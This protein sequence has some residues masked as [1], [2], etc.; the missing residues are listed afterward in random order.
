MFKRIL[1]LTLILLHIA[2]FG[3]MREALAY[4]SSSANYNLNADVNGGGSTERTTAASP[5]KIQFD[6]IGEPC[7][8]ESSS[9]NYILNAGFIP[10][11]QSNP[12]TLKQEIPNYYSWPVDSAKNNAFDLDDYFTS[13]EGY[14][15]TYRASGNNSIKVTIEPNTHVVIFSANAGWFGV[16]TIRFIATD[17]E[18]NEFTSNDIVLQVAAASGT[19]NKPVIIDTELSPMPVKEGDAVTLTVKAIDL[20]GKKL[21]FAYSAYF[22]QASTW[23]DGV[24]WYSRAAWQA[25]TSGSK[26]YPLKITITEDPA[27]LSDARDLVVNVGNVNNPPV[28]PPIADIT[29]SEGQAQAVQIKPQAT[30]ADNDVIFY[31]YSVPF[32]T[33]GKWFPGYDDEGV[34]NVTVSAADGIDM[35]TRMAKVTVNHTNRPPK[36]NLTL[37]KYTVRPN[38]QI[39]I[40]VSVSDPDGDTMT[41]SLKKDGTEIANGSIT[42]TYSSTTSFSNIANHKISVTLTDAAGASVTDTKDVDVADPNANRDAINPVMGDFNGDALSDLGLYNSDTAAWEI[43]LAD[44]LAPEAQIFKSASVWLNMPD[45][46]TGDKNWWPMGGDFNGDALTDAGLYNNITGEFRIATSTGAGF[47]DKG[48]VFKF[49]EASYSWQPFTGNFN[50]DKYTDFGLY[51]KETGEVRVA[52]GSKDGF[53]AFKAWATLAS[54]SDCVV[55]GGDYNGDGLMDLCLFRKSSGEFKVVFSN[56]KAFV[57]GAVWLSGFANDKDALISDFNNDG[58]TDVGYWNKDTGTWYYAISTGEKFVNKGVWWDGFGSSSDESATTGDFD[59]NGITDA[60]VFDKDQLGINRWKIKLSTN[61]PADLLNLIDNGIGGQTKVSYTY[62]ATSEN[63]LLPFPVC[64]AS[65]IS[66]VN[67]YPADRAATYTQEFSFSGGYFDAVEREFRGFAKVKVTDISDP[68]PAQHSYAETYFYQGRSDSGAVD[69]DQGAKKGQIRMIRAYDGDNHLISEVVNTY[70][71]QKSGPEESFLGF[72]ALTGV[73]STVYEENGASVITTDN[74]IYDNIGN[75]IEAISLGAKA[76]DKRSTTTIYSQPYE[77]GYNRPLKINIKDKDEN[78]V[79][80]KDFEYDAKGNLYRDTVYIINSASQANQVAKTNITQYSYDSYGNLN[81]S[82]DALGN[83]VITNYEDKFHAYPESVVNALGYSFTYIYEPKFGVIRTATDANGAVTATSY[84]TLGRPLEAV[85]ALGEATTTFNYGDDFRSKT[86]ANALG[87]FKTEYIDG[88]GRTY[89]VI[90]N[91]EDGVRS[92]LV[93]SETY[94]NKRGLKD[95]ESLP[96]YVDEDSAKIS[97]ARYEYD[98]RGRIKKTS[99]DFPGTTSDAEASVSY[100]TPLYTET[101]DSLGHRKGALKDVYG[102]IIEI[103]EF[104]SGEPEAKADGAFHTYYEYDIQNNLTKT[105]DNKGNITQVFY[106]SIGRKTRMIDPDMG[107]WAYEYDVLG[108]LVRQTDAKGQVLV[109]EYDQ[110][111]RLTKKLLRGTSDEVIS[112]YYY[113]DPSKANCVGRLSR[114]KDKS[115]LTDFFYDILGRETK[116]IKTV[117]GVEFMVQREY[118]VLDR[119]AKL[120]YPDGEVVNYVYSINSGLLKRVSSVSG[121]ASAVNYVKDIT[122]NAKGQ[123]TAI[124]YGNNTSTTYDYGPDLR[125][126]NIKTNNNQGVV[127]Q[128]LIYKFDA[129]GNV[130]SLTDNI[131][132]RRNNRQF[133]YDGLDRLTEE[134]KNNAVVSSYDYNSIGNMTYKSEMGVPLT[135]TYGQSAGPHAVTTAGGYT[136]QYDANGNMIRNRNKDLVYDAENRLAQVT[137]GSTIASFVYDGDGGLVKSKVGGAQPVEK[138]FIGSLYEKESGGKSRKHI[139]SGANKVC[140]VESSGPTYYFH[141]DHLGSS[142]VITDQVGNQSAYYEYAPYGATSRSEGNNVTDYK[143]TG[144]QLF[145]S[146]DLYHYGARFYDP[147]TGRFITAD[148]IV[149]APYDSQSLNRYAYCRNNPINYVDPSGHFFWFAPLIAAVIGAAL[150]AAVAAATGGNIGQGALMGAISGAIFWGAG[151][152]I[153]ILSKAMA[154]PA[155]SAA[156]TALT[157]GVHTIAGAASGALGAL[158]TGGDVGFNAAVGGIGAGASA[159]VGGVFPIKGDGLGA[160]AGRGVQ[161]TLVGAILG[162]GTS[163]VMGGSFGEGAAQGARTSAIAYTTNCI[164]AVAIP[165]VEYVG[166][167]LL[168]LLGAAAKALMVTIGIAVAT[169]AAKRLPRSEGRYYRHYTSRMNQESIKGSGDIFPS[170]KNADYG[171]G[172]YFTRQWVPSSWVGP[173]SAETYV[174]VWVPTSVYANPQVWNSYRYGIEQVYSGGSYPIYNDPSHP[175]IFGK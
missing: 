123:I 16:E 103:R 149:Q 52:L 93:S 127:L 11:I 40:T 118:D 131:T 9:T 174:D 107:T 4:V 71:V 104:V 91:G 30:D 5:N 42:S 111:N 25:P 8:G 153:G 83:K 154:I 146:I 125:L 126:S 135:M 102:N 128:D 32:D 54:G 141:S 147:V 22:V 17:T 48:V 37:S 49:S 76:D 10:V 79:S 47:S 64:V 113:D 67:T 84:D 171:A 45:A 77:I 60:A 72:P 136:Y 105:T 33:Q 87:L 150:G 34:Y 44:K 86:S 78:T 35:V 18:G 99:A 145:V 95:K 85:N 7:V 14:A 160:I 46:L 63:V 53:G 73:V 172:V 168:T 58:L 12:P 24:F 68:D 80:K 112:E 144:K 139:F 23:Q 43:C 90:S 109:F 96:H 50:G 148:S 170:G 21:N 142:N 101:T 61:K 1:S 124:Q 155:N 65:K 110:I 92:R 57:D 156:M 133:H 55:L 82:T 97:Y 94:F 13:P 175:P 62:A 122:Y 140:T 3:P 28:L 129:N 69:L 157:T 81:S 152:V 169:E 151:Q 20:D 74:L 167:E 15:L 89:K 130:T 163:L 31:Y 115:G 27:G 6:S 159:W 88:L 19:P 134:L 108:N 100:I 29:A 161:R 119:L 132:A 164:G 26:H 2:T 138:V 75:V 173:S 98:R 59:G 66:L 165:A 137:E 51:N 114:V 162:G 121:G 38:E 56:N 166:A 41:F 117:D 70:A 143:F 120:T 116:S 36:P 106:D 39:D 158:A